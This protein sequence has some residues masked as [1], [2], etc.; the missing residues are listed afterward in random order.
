MMIGRA[1]CGLPSQAPASSPSP[2]A[3]KKGLIS[4][5]EGLSTSVKTTPMTTSEMTVGIR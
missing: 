1:S 2:I 3:F 4:P 5:S